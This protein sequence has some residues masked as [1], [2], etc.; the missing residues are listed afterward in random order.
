MRMHLVEVLEG[1]RQL[2]QHRLGI[3]Q[4]HTRHVVAFEGVHEALGDAMLCGLQTGVLMGL[5]P[6]ERASARVSA[7]M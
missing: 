5:R 6:S 4:V 7:A 3:P 2:C 1:G